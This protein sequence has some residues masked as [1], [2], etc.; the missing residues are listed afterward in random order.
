VTGSNPLPSSYFASALAYL[1]DP[2]GSDT[3]TDG[4]PQIF[5]ADPPSTVPEPGSLFL[6]GTGFGALAIG[7]AATTRRRAAELSTA[8]AWTSAS[9]EE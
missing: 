6:L 4:Q 7:L 3:W 9:D 5:M 8:A 1:P 2:S